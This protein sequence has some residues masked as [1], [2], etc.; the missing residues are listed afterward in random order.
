MPNRRVFL[1]HGFAVTAA[2]TVGSTAALGALETPVLR[3]RAASPARA[4]SVAGAASAAIFKL[5]VDESLPAAS[6]FAAAAARRGAPVLVIGDDAGAAW[7]DTI[8]PRLKRGAVALGGFTAGPAL[9]CL[10]LLA[11]DYALRT[12]YRIA[13]VRERGR[14]LHT[15]EGPA[16]LA[17]AARALEQTGDAWPEDA[18]AI[19]SSFTAERAPGQ[20]IAPIGREAPWRG[21]ALPLL[22]VAGARGEAAPLYS[23]LLAP[24]HGRGPLAGA[25]SAAMLGARLHETSRP[26]RHGPSFT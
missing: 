25:A 4:A 7:R 8:E 17:D 15:F 16:E 5:L 21:R 20:E 6:A 3:A 10:E 12:V 19:A 24:V 11:R 13:H 9:F 26:R 18:A 2:V 23:W 22:D 1:Q 14:W